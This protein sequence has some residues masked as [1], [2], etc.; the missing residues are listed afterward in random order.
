MPVLKHLLD[1][2][3]ELFVRLVRFVGAENGGNTGKPFLYCL[4]I[5][6]Y[7][8]AEHDITPINSTSLSL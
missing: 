2:T 5:F 3:S 7:E 6:L 1:I 4:H 8:W